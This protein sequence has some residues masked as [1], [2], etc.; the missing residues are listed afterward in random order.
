MSLSKEDIALFKDILK[1][2]NL[3]LKELK[4]LPYEKVQMLRKVMQPEH[5]SKEEFL[6][7]P[8]VHTKCLNEQKNNLN[9]VNDMLW[10]TSSTPNQNFNKAL[11]DTYA[12]IDLDRVRVDFSDSLSS[13]NILRTKVNPLTGAVSVIKIDY[14]LMNYDFYIQDNIK[15][16]LDKS[17]NFVLSEQERIRAKLVYSEYLN[18]QKTYNELKL[19]ERNT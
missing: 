18:F 1:D 19:G 17:N 15:A 7:K 16:M 6:R 14:S 4:S 3:S 8:I 11:F 10:A 5:L 9:Q 2:D 13:F 12:N